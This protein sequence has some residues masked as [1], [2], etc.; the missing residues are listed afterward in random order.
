MAHELTHALQDQ[1]FDVSP[2]LQRIQGN[3]DAMLARSAVLEGDALAV[4]LD[5]ILKPLGMDFINLPDLA[6]M[7]GV[8]AALA[9]PEFKVFA[10]APP[11]LRELLLFPY[12]GGAVFLQSF[13]QAHSWREVDKIYRDLPQS[14]EQIL[15]PSKYWTIRD[16]PTPVSHGS[17]PEL[18]P[19]SWKRI[20]ANVLGEFNVLQVLKRY[21]D[22]EEARRSAGG[23]DGDSIQLFQDRQGRLALFLRTV[24]DSPEEARQFSDSYRRLL[25]KKY[26]QATIRDE[27]ERVVWDSETAG[28]VVSLEGVWVEALEMDK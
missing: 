16:E 17:P 8:Q 4:M 26:P 23:W 1:H 14:S 27:E 11:Y 24:W 22:A 15:H 9:N 5:Y 6:A 10:S 18:E 20:Y 25:S 2:F 7:T 12:T 13:R 3:D 28:G 21:L 19:D